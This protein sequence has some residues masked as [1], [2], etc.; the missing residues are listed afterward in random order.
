[1]SPNALGLLKKNLNQSRIHVVV[2]N[3]FNKIE[4]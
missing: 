3:N 1:M 2:F 4:H